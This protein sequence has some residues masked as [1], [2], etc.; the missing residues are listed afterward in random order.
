MAAALALAFALSISKAVLFSGTVLFSL[1]FDL[2][3]V[4]VFLK[5]STW[6]RSRD[7]P[8]RLRDVAA[9]IV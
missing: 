9:S 7:K 5:R 4:A 8:Q 3:A 6:G 1:F 2:T